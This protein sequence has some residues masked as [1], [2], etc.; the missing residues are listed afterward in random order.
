[1]QC[2]TGHYKGFLLQSSL[3]LSWGTPAFT[4]SGHQCPSPRVLPVGTWDPWAGA[5]ESSWLMGLQT[6]RR[7]L[8]AVQTLCICNC[9]PGLRAFLI[10][11]VFTWFHLPETLPGNPNSCRLGQDPPG[12]SEFL[13]MWAPERRGQVIWFEPRPLLPV[14]DSVTSSKLFNQCLHFLGL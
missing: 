2:Q 12:N 10:L 4:S 8:G 5:L 14:T 9:N 13:R 1:M 7:H 3:P 11:T 6:S